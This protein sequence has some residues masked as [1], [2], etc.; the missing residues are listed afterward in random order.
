VH[1]IGQEREAVRRHYPKPFS[2][3]GGRTPPIIFKARREC[4]FYSS[5]FLPSIKTD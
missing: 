1:E 2:N 3:C 4:S 5:V